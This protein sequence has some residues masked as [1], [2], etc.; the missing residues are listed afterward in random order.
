MNDES[1][2][3]IQRHVAHLR[4]EG[5]GSWAEPH[6]LETHLRK[7]GEL[8]ARSADQYGAEWARL[9]GRWHDL[10][11]YRP[12]F[13]DY[14]RRQTGYRDDA[15][16]AHIEGAKN[17]VTHST[18]GAIHARRQL[19]PH[20]DL[21][22]YLIAGHHA[23]LPDWHSS[24]TGRGC[25]SSRL[26]NA[27]AEY[28]ESLSQPIPKT[29]LAGDC[30]KRAS[31]DGT[32]EGLHL[33]IRLLF[34]ALVDADFLDTEKYMNPARSAQRS[35]AQSLDD[36]RERL[37]R[38]LGKF[39][40]DS[41]INR[42][43]AEILACCRAAAEQ[44]PGL[45]SL[46][47]PT[48]G[49]KT[50]ASLA[51]AL[52][53]ARRH[54]KRRVIYA[55]P[56]TSIIEQNAAVFRDA[57]GDDAVLEHHSNLDADPKR[58]NARSRLAAENWDAPLIVTTNVQLFE[59]LFA[60][61]PSRCRKL[62]NLV[63]SVIVLDEAQQLPRDFLAPITATMKQL[64][65][66]Y[67]VSW[68]L[69]TAT[70]PNLE[71]Q[72]DAFGRSAFAGLEGV[73]EII[74]EPAALASELKRVEI[75][76]PAAGAPARGWQE[77]ADELAA[78]PCALAIVNSRK[79]ALALYQALP[80]DGGRVHLSA[81]MC[82]E[83]RAA[84]IAEIRTRLQARREGDDRPLR[85]VSTQ[86]V[87]AG[88]DLDFPLVYRALAG[89]DSIAQA[90]GRCNRE[91]R[92]KGPGRVV[93]FEPESEAPM[94]WLRQG[95][96]TTRELLPEVAEDPLA[97]S[98]FARYFRLMYG[99]GELDKNGIQKLL[100]PPGRGDA[101]LAMSLRTAAR[102]FRMIDDAGRRSSCAT[103]PIRR[104]NRPSNSGWRCSKPTPA[105]AGSTASCN[106][107]ASICTTRYSTPCS[108]RVI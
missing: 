64:A 100:T 37:D 58:E 28:R 92:L 41:L 12:A 35:G 40:A 32:A 97:P 91:G 81:M 70:Q 3:G 106:A 105:N 50:L 49:G 18:A 96:D 19:G 13:Q 107:T 66:H 88:V 76:F 24:E 44:P 8:A 69:C 86:L 48:G 87:E 31:P 54:G 38:H 21:L 82:A 29:I 55:I 7:V 46:T 68:L 43:R 25:L 103:D 34:S 74:P 60:A 22:A 73:R 11:K 45:F 23:G 14:L 79:D 52:E 108:L 98:A 10:G 33:W 9:A 95:V 61:R 77:I 65:E 17:R 102:N 27:E 30:P 84:V 59:S 63:N 99:K 20:G 16:D 26:Q 4:R 53:H 72:R 71:G 2:N 78:A 47:V 6:S 94:G 15:E 85:V 80:D 67:G 51:F 57:L 83:H 39:C 1:D 75:E 90:A 62:H 89:L 56:Y 36:L 5:D 42:R 104:A 101:P 93:V